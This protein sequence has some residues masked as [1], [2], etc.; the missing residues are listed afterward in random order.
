M[1]PDPTVNF[2]RGEVIYENSRVREW[3]R[4]WKLVFGVTLPFWPMFYTFEIYAN[5][6]APSL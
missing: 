5:D 1:N 3:V 6:G 4:L 2:E